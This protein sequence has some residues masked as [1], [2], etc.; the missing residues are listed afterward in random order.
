MPIGLARLS[1][2]YPEGVP[3]AWGINGITSVLA[4][5][6]AIAVAIT[7]GFAAPRCSPWPATSARSRTPPSGAGR[8]R[9]LLP[10]RVA[11]AS[12]S[13]MPPE[14]T[15]DGRIVERARRARGRRG[16][17]CLGRP[18]GRLG[19]LRGRWSSAR[20]GTTRGGATSSS[21]VRGDRRQA[22]QHAELVRWNS[23]KR[24][25]GD[26]AEAGVPVVPTSFVGPGEPGAR[27]RWR[28]GGEAERLG[29]RPRLRALRAGAHE[30]ARELIE[31]DPGQRPHGDGPALPA[32]R[33]LARRD[34]GPADRRRAR[35]RPAQAGG[36]APRRGRPGARRRDRRRG[37]DV[38]PR[39]GDAGGRRGRAR[40]RAQGDRGDQ[41]SASTT[42]RSTPAST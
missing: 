39:A 37:G 31:G 4:S 2:L 7:W 12:F 3:W 35:A 26:L 11:I 38:R 21:L 20:P 27:A 8:R 42:C 18:G 25:L 17:A 5:V 30:R 33:R 9:S 14:F 29:R 22:A 15:D 28:G 16:G 32:E 1:A 13:A 34:R 10:V 40:A 41:S 24:Y 23:D 36:A 6:L 19:A